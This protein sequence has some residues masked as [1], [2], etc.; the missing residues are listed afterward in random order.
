MAK[1]RADEAV[2]RAVKEIGSEGR[3]AGVACRVEDRDTGHPKADCEDR[4]GGHTGADGPRCPRALFIRSSD[5]S[6]RM[7]P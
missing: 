6:L 5:A 2:M 4:I 1:P 7:S 3:T